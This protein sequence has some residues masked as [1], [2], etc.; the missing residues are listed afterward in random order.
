MTDHAVIAI[1]PCLDLDASEA[2]YRSL[3]F[4]HA[5][6]YDGYRILSDDKGGHIHLRLAG[7]GEIS[8]E[9]NP[10]GLYVYAE[11]VDEIARRFDAL[12]IQKP[13]H[14][15]W[16]MYEFALSDPGGA[17]VRVGWPSGALATPGTTTNGA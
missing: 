12:L 2:F 5:A 11:N 10:C 15:P 6:A 16:G 3:D 4:I 9:S 8:R 14:R 7:E 17:L 1:M 13:G